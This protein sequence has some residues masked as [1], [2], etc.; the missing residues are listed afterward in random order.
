MKR[1]RTDSLDRCC[2]KAGSGSD[3]PALIVILAQN[4]RIVV[5]MLFALFAVA[6]I[7]QGMFLRPSARQGIA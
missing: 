2:D 1:C 6:R 7:E 3:C 5:A 4:S